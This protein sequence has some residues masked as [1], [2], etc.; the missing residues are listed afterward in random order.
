ML[1]ES[2]IEQERV[3]FEAWYNVAH[4]FYEF[5]LKESGKYKHQEVQIAFG[6][7]LAAIE[8]QEKAAVDGVIEA[9]DHICN[10]YNDGKISL[11]ALVELLWGAAYVEGVKYQQAQEITLKDK[12]HA[13]YNEL[14]SRQVKSEPS[15]I[16]ADE[17]YEM[18]K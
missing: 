4:G 16:T 14:A 15:G 1:S 10:Q 6:S 17:L 18:M 9:R 12:V 2:R 3:R 13:L 5:Y 7:W 11:S 8:A